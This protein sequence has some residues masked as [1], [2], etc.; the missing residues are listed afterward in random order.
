MDELP[1]GYIVFQIAVS[2]K[3]QFVILFVLVPAT[4]ENLG[5][6]KYVATKGVKT[7]T[8]LCEKLL[9]QS[10]PQAIKSEELHLH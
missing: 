3:W 2:M 8:A 6:H 9:V 7:F 4:A 5:L 1:F 10:L